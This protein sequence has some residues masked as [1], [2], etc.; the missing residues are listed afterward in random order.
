MPCYSPLTGWRGRGGVI[1]F[2]RS[3]A[4]GFRQ[5]VSCGQCIGCRLERSRQWAIRIMHEAQLH[6]EPYGSGNAFITLTYSDLELPVGGTL[7]KS[8]FQG[9]MKRLRSRLAPRR[10][11]FFHCGE[12]GEKFSRPHYHGAIFG[13]EFPDKVFYKTAGESRLYVSRFLDDIW[14]R[15]FCTVGDVSFESAGYVARYCLKKQNGNSAYDHYWISDELTGEAHRV[16]PEYCTMSN[17]PGIG[18]GW[19]AKFGS[20]VFPSDEVVT[21]GFRSKPPRYYD[22]L[23]EVQNPEDFDRVKRDRVLAARR[24]SGDSTPERLEVREICKRSQVDL[25]HRSYENGT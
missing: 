14:G 15:G 25:L 23:Y 4:C 6:E 3:D 13:Y 21:R 9:F 16:E 1:V 19:F 7:V 17:R 20:D 2:K 12:Y 10:I 18:A 22:G 11:R 8:H 24:R 5:V